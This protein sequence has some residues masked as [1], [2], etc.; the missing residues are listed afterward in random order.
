MAATIKDIA[1]KTGLGLATI[2]KYL[3]GGN[4]LEE[5]KIAIEEAIRILDFRVNEFARGLK[6]SKSKTI[7]VVIPELSN[8]FFTSI[9]TIIEDILRQNGYGILVCDC[10]TDE[11]LEYEATEF[12]VNKMVDGIICMPV[13]R[14]GAHLKLPLSK[15]IPVVLIDRNVEGLNVDAV[16]VDNVSASEAAVEY[17]IDHGHREIGII[18]GPSDIF[19]SHQ[20]QLGYTQAFVKKGIFPK[21]GLVKYGEYTVESGYE[22]L[23]QLV[24]ENEK[25][26]AIFVTNYEL[27]LGAII[28]INE[29][30][31]KV[32]EQLSLIGFDNMH[33]AQVVKPRLTIISQPIQKIAENVA[34]IMLKRLVQ[35]KYDEAKIVNL[36]T[37]LIIG[38]SVLYKHI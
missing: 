6:T 34:H 26:S 14:D 16:L 30:G 18:C 19:T 13:S 35:D 24:M 20:R 3:N 29:L 17:L 2:S 9:I 5:N 11:K 8:L 1:K 36:S 23:K 37:E 38:E 15:G 10:R 4:V 28:A 21:Q 22:S 7:G 25:L 32:P 33:L 27:T 31:I 12:L